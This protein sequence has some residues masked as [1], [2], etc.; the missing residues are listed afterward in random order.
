MLKNEAR[1]LVAGVERAVSVGWSD[2]EPDES[3]ENYTWFHVPSDGRLDVVVLSTEPI[4]YRGHYMAGAVQPCSVPRCVHCQNGVGI[5]KRVAL[6]VFSLNTGCRGLLE[7]GDGTAR[8]IRAL[9]PVSGL[10]RGV[11]VSLSKEH[12]QQRGRILCEAY[13]G[14][15]VAVELP[16]EQDPLVSL[17]AQWA[18][19]AL[20][21][22]RKD[23]NAAVKLRGEAENSSTHK[24]GE[25]VLTDQIPVSRL[26]LAELKLRVD[27]RAA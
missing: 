24:P 3:V 15:F 1:A 8:H 5:L 20:R 11:A 6:S 2:E 7:L 10:L 19:L 18:K 16:P 27:S 21:H 23:G 12:Q 22:G 17:N 26:T 25:A 13:T 4:C 9:M 14:L